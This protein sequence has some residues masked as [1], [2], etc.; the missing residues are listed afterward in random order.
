MKTLSLRQPWASLIFA[1]K[2]VENRN[3]STGYRGRIAIHASV[4]AAPPGQRQKAEH[5]A[6]MGYAPR[7]DLA[8]LPRGAVLGTVEL[9]GV[10]RE[11]E[12]PWTT[13]TA[14]QWLLASPE[15]FE[16]PV[17]ATG[18]LGLWEWDQ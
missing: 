16:R 13:D 6:D 9:V 17:P 10:E 2:N 15:L 3:W 14:F 18:R 12:S 8:D 7:L 4:A 5:L 1:G 11:H